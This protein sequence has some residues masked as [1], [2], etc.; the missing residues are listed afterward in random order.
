MGL[1]DRPY[2]RDTGGATPG[3]GL[4]GLRF[5]LPRPRRA[6][7]ALMAG[8][9]VVLFLPIF[10]DAK[11]VERWL[12]LY[13]DRWEQAWRFLSFQFLHRGS[14]HLLMNLMGLYFFGPPLEERWGAGRFLAFYLVCGVAAGA[15]FLLL[16][17]A[18]HA[19]AGSLV[20][21]SGGVLG[22]VAACAV[23]MP[24]M[25]IFLIPIRWATAIL[26]AV[27]GL[28]VVSALAGQAPDGVSDAAHLGGMIAGGAWAMEQRSAPRRGR[29]LGGLRARLQR[30]AWKRKQEAEARRRAEVDRILDKV[31]QEGVA[32]LS[33]REKKT[34]QEETDRLRESGP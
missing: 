19:G 33:G 34:L 13:T 20:G 30:G 14:G 23:Q 5:Y 16:G 17:L 15:A 6:V 25:R 4:G 27:Y 21:A 32:S 9:V 12:A 7:I 3:A 11:V 2:W 31:H 10:L 28:T 22:C 8:C 29:G 1:G 24:D 26:L 18:T